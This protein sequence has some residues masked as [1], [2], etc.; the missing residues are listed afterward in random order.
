MGV[1]LAHNHEVEPML[2]HQRPKRLM[3]GEV[4]TQEGPAMRRPLFGVFA[5]PAL[6][7]P[8]LT[9]LFVMA[10]LRHDGLGGQGDTLGGAWAND[11]RCDRR[12]IR[13]GGAIGSLTAETVGEC[14]ALDEKY[15][16]PSSATNSWAP[17]TRKLAHMPCCAR[18]LQIATNTGSSA[19]GAIGSSRLRDRK[20]V[21]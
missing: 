20:S 2:A 18:P 17:S 7:R 4:I 16:V 15:W 13:E 12:M 8:P 3:A 11:H 6:A 14:M 5:Y 9:V 10:V 21:V 1:G 19:L